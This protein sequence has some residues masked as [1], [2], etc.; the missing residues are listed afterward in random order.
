LAYS[1]PLGEQVREMQIDFTRIG[2]L[3]DKR[4]AAKAMGTAKHHKYILYQVSSEK[5]TGYKDEQLTNK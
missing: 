4:D 5:K 2:G 3:C 1:A